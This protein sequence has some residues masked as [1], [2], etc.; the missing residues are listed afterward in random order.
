MRVPRLHLGRRSEAAVEYAHAN[1][2]VGATPWRD[3][4][5]C[6]VDLELTSL[7]PASG[8]IVSFGAVSVDDGRVVA[9]GAVYGLVRPLRAVPEESVL[10]HG[11]RSVDL[12]EAPVIDDAM[13]TLLSAMA[14]RVLVVHAADVERTFLRLP[15]RRQGARLREPVLDTQVLG[16]L[17]LA[18]R[19]GAAPRWLSLADLV[20]ALGLPS[21]RPHHALGD[22]LTT[23]QAFIAVAT[24][25]ET[26]GPVTV[27]SLARAP[28]RLER[29]LHYPAVSPHTPT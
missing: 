19:S 2:A 26:F 25:L 15:L 4:R 12:A 6:V 23:A 7:D 27:R 20:T 5:Y 21:H 13:A 17:L 10:V 16:R 8:E 1:V 11:I 14:G 22:A 24:H 18:E 28:T 9:H 29:L 3:A